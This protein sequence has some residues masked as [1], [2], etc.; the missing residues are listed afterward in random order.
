MEDPVPG[1]TVSSNLWRA[2]RNT[3]GL[4]LPQLN[5]AEMN[6]MK[7]KTTQEVFFSCPI[8]FIEELPGVLNSHLPR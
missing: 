3:S 6:I 2:S 8:F 1:C 5:Q 7:N 4:G